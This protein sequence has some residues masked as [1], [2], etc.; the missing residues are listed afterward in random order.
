MIELLYL[1]GAIIFMGV[2]TV[3]LRAGIVNGKTDDVRFNRAL[4]QTITVFV[5]IW[6]VLGTTGF[7]V[8]FTFGIIYPV[9]NGVLGGGAFILF[10]KGL[11]NVEASTARP[12][13]SSRMIIPVSLGIIMLEETF[14]IEKMIGI[15]F[16]MMAIIL[17]TSESE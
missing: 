1:F 4:F 5:I 8:P 7:S 11:E 17:L 14:T 13:L 6:A 10:C 9:I 2:K 16:V 3:L 12:L 15:A